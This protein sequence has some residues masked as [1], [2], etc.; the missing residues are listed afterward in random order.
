M[1]G[2]K[3]VSRA[4]GRAG[5]MAGEGQSAIAAPLS[6]SEL[7]QLDA[8]VEVDKSIRADDHFRGNALDMFPQVII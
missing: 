5:G 1:T 2:S 4:D 8:F 7:E 3:D 6:N